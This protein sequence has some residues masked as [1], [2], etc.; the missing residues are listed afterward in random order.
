MKGCMPIV[1]G[2][3]AGALLC[4]CTMQKPVESLRQSGDHSYRTGDYVAAAHDYEMITERYPG[5]WRA[6]YQLGMARLELGEL[7]AARSALEI[8]HARRPRDSDVIEALA[9]VMLRQDD[10]E[11]V[12]DL[13]RRSTASSPSTESY[14]RLARYSIALDDPDSARAQ[15]T[16]DL[17]Q[18][19]GAIER[20]DADVAA[21]NQITQGQ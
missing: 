12:F 7:S 3:L 19:P 16:G 17:G 15:C 10:N 21:R 4:S 8:A 1:S 11:A 18:H 9:D 14:L 6:Q 20:L 13:L 5:D 2:L